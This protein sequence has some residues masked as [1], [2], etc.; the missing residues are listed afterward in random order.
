M[1]I[2]QAIKE[3]PKAELH[4]HLLGAIRPRMLLSLIQEE[5]PDSSYRTVEDINDLFQ[6]RTFRHFILAYTEIVD[7]V[8]QEKHFEQITFEM[9]EDCAKC[10][11]HYVEASFS[12]IDH[13]QRGLGYE[14]MLDAINRGIRRAKRS[15]GIECSIR[16]DFVRNEGPRG[17]MRILDLIEAKSDNV[18]SVDIGGSEDLF[19]PKPFASVFHRARR[20]GLHTVAHAG[21]AAGPKSVWEAIQYLKVE[22]VG[23]AVSAVG[24]KRLLDRMKSEGIGIESCPISNVRTGAVQA[25]Q[26]HP[27]R[28]FYDRELLV[29]VNSDDPTLFQTDLNN[30][31]L[32][33]NQKLGFSILDLF[34]LSANAIEV[35]FLS[36]E[37]KARMR[38][39]FTKEAE[40]IF[41]AVE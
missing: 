1:N 12:A 16:I 6:F 19:P 22:R 32:Q 13:I 2:D 10:N 40:Q 5:D 28:E 20:L 31:Y 14:E 39:S 27:I 23:H 34:Q 18:V 26:D 15:F 29:T 30:E 25:L 33:L 8:T 37:A 38:D 17:A 11:T 35:S 4:I 36:E 3:L 24:D 21:E 9:L 7:Y 41:D